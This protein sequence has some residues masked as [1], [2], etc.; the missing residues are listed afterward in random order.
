MSNHATDGSSRGV[1]HMRGQLT[2]GEATPGFSTNAIELLSN[3]GSQFSD[4]RHQYAQRGQAGR[5]DRADVYEH[6]NYTE[7][8]EC[9]QQPARS[10]VSRSSHPQQ[11]QL[12]QGL[13]ASENSQRLEEKWR[14]KQQ[15]REQHR[16]YKD[17]LIAQRS[18][19]RGQRPS[20]E[21]KGEDE[22]RQSRRRKPC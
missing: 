7:R 17:H 16:Q 21:P 14:A 2:D 22:S 12:N 6:R 9:P 19:D 10:G 1:D 11:R 15:L 4:V 18:A 3:V 20:K 8:Y 13:Q 5:P